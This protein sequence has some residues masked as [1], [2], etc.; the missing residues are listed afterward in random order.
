MKITQPINVIIENLPR[1]R[2]FDTML[3]LL[4]SLG[5]KITPLQRPKL[6]GSEINEKEFSSKF[7]NTCSILFSIPN[8][9]YL[10]P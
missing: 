4:K 7:A 3:N 8:I 6:F 2:D 10:E 5:S 9:S 1:V